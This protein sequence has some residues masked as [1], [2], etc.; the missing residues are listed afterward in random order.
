[1]QTIKFGILIPTRGDRPNFLKNCLAQIERQTIKPTIINIVD[2]TP[3]HNE[4]DITRRYK[5][6]YEYLS[7][8][9]LDCIFFIEDDDFYAKDYFETMLNKWEENDRP[10]LLGTSY[11]I[12]YHTKLRAWF[13]MNHTE[14]SSAMSTLIKPNLPLTWCADN[15]PYTDIHIWSQNFRKVIFTPKKNICL[16]MK[17]G[18]GLCGG[19][20]HLNKLERFKNDDSNLE[21]LRFNMDLEP[22]KFFTSL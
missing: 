14:R 12:Y 4:K 11:T 2:F 7:T 18:V 8:K 17:H 9:N 10:D 21:F 16:G 6:G 15:D 22:F 3:R 13:H 19:N 20:N 5:V 1:M